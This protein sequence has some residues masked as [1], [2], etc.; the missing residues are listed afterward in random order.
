MNTININSSHDLSENPPKSYNYS[1]PEKLPSG[2]PSIRLIS[3]LPPLPHE[4]DDSIQYSHEWHLHDSTP[5]L[6]PENH[7]E[8]NPPLPDL[9]PP[10]SPI[11]DFARNTAVAAAGLASPRM[12]DSIGRTTAN[13]TQKFPWSERRSGKGRG[14]KRLS[15]NDN[16]HHFSLYT[17]GSNDED[18][19]GLDGDSLRVSRW[20]LHKWVLCFSVLSVSLPLSL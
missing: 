5:S 11:V 15:E 9:K 4:V 12:F 3:P 2:I 13:F 17:E 18:G 19:A 20:T 10:R 1:S 6:S 14:F 8:Y 7:R 16:G